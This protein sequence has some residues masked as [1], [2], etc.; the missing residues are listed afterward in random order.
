M[1]KTSERIYEELAEL[2]QYIAANEKK[3]KRPR[4]ECEKAENISKTFINYIKEKKKEI[5]ILKKV[6]FQSHLPATRFE[7][8]DEELESALNASYSILK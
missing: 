2:E 1:S 8:F 5:F 6:M 4:D 7:T 3:L